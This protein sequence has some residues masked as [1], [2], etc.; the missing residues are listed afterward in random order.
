MGTMGDGARQ[1]IDFLVRSGIR[2]WQVCPL[3]P[4]GYGDSPYQCLSAFAGNPYL[5]DLEPLVRYGLLYSEE[6]QGLREEDPARIDYG[7]Q[8][9]VRYP[10]L[11][12]AYRRFR[13]DRAIEAEYGDFESFREEHRSWLRAYALFRSLK[14]HYQ[15][16]PWW[17]WEEADREWKKVSKRR[18]TG[19]LEERAEEE[20]FLQY[21]FFSQWGQLRHHAAERG[22]EIIGDIPI[23]VSMDSADVWQHSEL[24]LLDR[25][26]RP[27]EVAGVPPDY[28]SADGQLW[29]NPLYH[30]K[31]ME[32][33]GFSW[34]MDRFK[35]NFN[36]FDVVQLDHFRGFEAAYHVP[37]DASDA[38]HGRW[39]P[40]PG[41]RFFK[42]LMKTFPNP[43]I[44]LE[45]LGMITDS[46]RHLKE[47][48]GLPGMAVLQ[49]AFD[50]HDSDFLP[51]NLIPNSVL[52]T[53]THDNDTSLGWYKNAGE[54][55]RDH[56]RRYLRVAGDDVPW[57][58]I[59]CGFQCV[60]RLFVV[61]VQDLLALGSGARLNFPGTSL[62]NWRWRLTGDQLAGLSSQTAPHLQ[63]L[64]RLYGRPGG[65]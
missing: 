38:R 10:V 46:V 27:T 35:I 56:L 49:F 1:F 11:H 31:R 19:D 52:Y 3:G 39:V 47:A 32:K 12:L 54:G 42:Q 4:T 18:L 59:R 43:R 36:L 24:F 25:D 17:S 33:D 37:A 21:L 8:F 51:H 58:L 41:Q 20:I 55:T 30:W 2:Y 22:V 65:S 61:P 26:L 14:A 28:F 23:F 50:D 9:Q 7:L 45:D 6:V 63:E 15:G 40:G 29:G 44:I 60:S 53:G 57:D 5:I 13:D 48:T 16:K 34:W 62:G 64:G